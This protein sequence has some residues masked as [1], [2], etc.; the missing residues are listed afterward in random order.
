LRRG[1]EDALGEIQAAQ[2]L[3]K[4]PLVEGESAKRQ[5]SSRTRQSLKKHRKTG[6][7]A[8]I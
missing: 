2:R 7:H 4:R 1:A 8:Q 5:P 3:V 6:Y